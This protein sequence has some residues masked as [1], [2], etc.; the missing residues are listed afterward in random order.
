MKV[1][2]II[3]AYNEEK[4]IGNVIG[5]YLKYYTKKYG[6]EFELFVMIDGTDGTLNIC[7]QFSKKFPNLKLDHSK[8]RRGKGAA[9]VAGFKLATGDF[10]GFTDADDSILPFEFDKLIDSNSDCS[11]ASRKI[12]GSKI[13]KN[14]P[15]I[16][17]FASKGFNV[18]VNTMFGLNLKDTQCGAKVFKYETIKT[19]LPELK[20]NGFE[21]DVEL[22]WRVKKNGFEIKEVPIIW[23]HQQ[24][25]SFSL[26]EAPKM[27]VGLLKMRFGE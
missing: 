8:K 5:Q 16:R 15:A 19:I 25:S 2:L 6:K 7:K 12:R 13:L 23:A 3:P 4:R 26:N 10:I 9:I 18:L 20:S 17:R 1:S 22:L 14:Q 11:I 24:H 27:F 21:F